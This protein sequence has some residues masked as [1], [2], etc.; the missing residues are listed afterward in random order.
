MDILPFVQSIFPHVVYGSGFYSTPCVKLHIGAK[1]ITISN[2]SKCD[3]Q[4]GNETIHQVIQL[5]RLLKEKI[6]INKIKLMDTSVIY[7][8]PGSDPDSDPG[9]TCSINMS[10]YFIL[11]TGQSWYNR[12]G[13]V[14][15][16]HSQEFEFNAKVRSWSVFE[17]VK[18]GLFQKN[19][20]KLESMEDITQAR[21]N[22]AKESFQIKSE[23]AAREFVEKFFGRF[24]PEFDPTMS[25]GQIFSIVKE[26]KMLENCVGTRSKT[27]INLVNYGFYLFEYENDLELVL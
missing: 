19:L 7:L 9:S 26:R 27:L 16:T 20:A 23:E 1:F 14:S 22:K 5:G 2:I 21:K 17:Y 8:D 18:N 10:I 6:G 15:S 3:E 25:I 13:F 11:S 24:F 4:S 12:A